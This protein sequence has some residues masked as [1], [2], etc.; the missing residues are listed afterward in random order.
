ME[1]E[2]SKAHSVHIYGENFWAHTINYRWLTTYNILARSTGRKYRNIHTFISKITWKMFNSP[3]SRKRFKLKS[4][5][6]VFIYGN[7]LIKFFGSVLERKLSMKHHLIRRMEDGKGLNYK[8]FCKANT[9][10]VDTDNKLEWFNG[11][12]QCVF[13]QMVDM[14]GRL[15]RK[16]FC[17]AYRRIDSKKATQISNKPHKLRFTTLPWSSFHAVKEFFFCTRLYCISTE[18][19]QKG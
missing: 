3:P 10:K 6:A 5:S 8:F 19:F 4:H 18:S 2:F 7:F 9:K 12:W 16:N 13:L 1:I 17:L 15:N 14:H 11:I